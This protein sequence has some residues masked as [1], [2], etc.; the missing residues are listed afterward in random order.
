MN[1]KQRKVKTDPTGALEEGEVETL[2]TPPE[3]DDLVRA[4]EAEAER[5]RLEQA[6]PESWYCARCGKAGKN[7]CAPRLRS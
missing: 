2:P 6:K 1:Q 4:A 7:V 5:L 3:I